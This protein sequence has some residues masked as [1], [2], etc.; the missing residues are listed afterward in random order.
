MILLV[1]CFGGLPP[2]IRPSYRAYQEEVQASESLR[3]ELVM[4][5]L[6]ENLALRQKM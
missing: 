5:E 3:Q 4:K 2:S 6:Q 1:A